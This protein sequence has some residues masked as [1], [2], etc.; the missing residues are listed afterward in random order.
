MKILVLHVFRFLLRHFFN[1]LLIVVVLALGRA[2][3]QE[4]RQYQAVVTE[5]AALAHAER[6]LQGQIERL[7]QESIDRLAG[8]T[9]DS[10]QGLNARMERLDAAIAAQNRQKNSQGSVQA[11]WDGRPIAQA[12]LDQLQADIAIRILEQERDFLSALQA[13]IAATQ[14]DKLQRAELQRLRAAHQKLYEDWQHA[15]AEKQAFQKRHPLQCWAGYGTSVHAQCRQLAA[16]QALLLEQNQRAAAAYQRQLALLQAARPLAPLPAYQVQRAE[17]EAL[18]L[19]LRSRWEQVQQQQDG[20]WVAKFSKPLKD[21]VGTALL[22]LVGVM[23]TPPLVKAFFYFVLASLAARR[24]AIELLPETSGALL[25]EAGHSSVSRAVEVDAAHELLVRP[26]FLQSASVQ[27]R[28]D[29]CWLLNPQF[30][31][32]SLAAGMVALTR[33]RPASTEQVYISSTRDP[34]SEIAILTLPQGAALVIQPHNLIGLVLRQGTPVRMTSHWRLGSL[35]AWLTLQLRYLAVH[36]PA[37]LMVQGCRGVQI[38]RADAGRSINQA[39]TIGFSAN[40]AYSTRRCET[41]SAYLLGR[42]ELLNDSFNGGPGFFFYEE[43][44]HAEQRKGLARSLEGFTDALLKV[45]G[46]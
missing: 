13:R 21:V 32:T 1:F 23:L 6:H 3:W 5:S 18:V 41:F 16:R 26:E 30:P 8:A 38:E 9:N 25:L 42:Q 34:L 11:L 14:S 37:R 44:P 19:P 10:L 17:L 12:Y 39:A 2:G 7:A 24:P 35:H 20:S 22:V 28:K 36:G 31:L 4:W 43:M 15:Q 27:G 40:L 33:I 29:T 46:I 45:F